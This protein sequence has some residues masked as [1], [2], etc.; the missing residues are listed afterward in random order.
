MEIFFLMKVIFSF[1][2]LHFVLHF[3]ITLPCGYFNM[4]VLKSSFK[5]AATICKMEATA[6]DFQK[7]E[8]NHGMYK[9]LTI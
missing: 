3:H 9:T 1:Y 2:L 8:Q 7:S 5:G 4:D 6:P